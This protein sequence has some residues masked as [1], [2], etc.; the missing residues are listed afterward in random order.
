MYEDTDSTNELPETELEKPTGGETSIDETCGQTMN[1][2][3]HI[4]G[5]YIAPAAHSEAKSEV[6]ELIREILW[7]DAS[8]PTKQIALLA[9]LNGNA[10]GR[11]VVQDCHFTTQV[12]EVSTAGKAKPEDRQASQT[13]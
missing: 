12:P 13:G 5:L 2:R 10:T 6:N 8:E 3:H 7:S 1:G 9:V 11:I 4:S